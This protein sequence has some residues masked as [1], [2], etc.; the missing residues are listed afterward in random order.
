MKE[1]LTPEGYEQTK[2]KLRDL[3]ARLAAIEK[4]TDLSSDHLASVRRSYKTMMREYTEEIM[5]Y[6]AKLAKEA[7]GA[8]S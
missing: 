4:R 1:T 2:E 3:E 5:L 6:E 8:G 7:S